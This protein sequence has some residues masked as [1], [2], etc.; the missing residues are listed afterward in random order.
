MNLIERVQAILLRPK[1]TWPV[2]AA[3]SADVASI[4]S[5]Y[6]L[7]VAAIPAV[8]GF[9]GLSLVGI[10]LPNGTYRIPV[11][12]GIVQMVIGYVLSLALVYVLALIVDALAPSFG[13]TKSQVQAL[14]LIAYGGT[15]GFVGGIFSLVPAL[16]ILGLL[17]GLYSIY[18]IYMGVAVTMRCPASKSALFT[19]VIVV[20]AVV[21]SLVLGAVTALVLPGTPGRVQG[22]S[23]V[24]PV[25]L[26]SAMS[27]L[28]ATSASPAERKLR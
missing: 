4:Y 16:S 28:A 23:S 12:T 1:T 19:A 15:A 17:A 9:I 5:N 7:Y 27:A 6:L 20:C 25:Q 24:Q 26:A 14:K 21:A 13:G 8:A 18:L 11:T 3:E 22:V 10:G 2:I